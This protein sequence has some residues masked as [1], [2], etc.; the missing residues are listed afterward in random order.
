MTPAEGEACLSSAITEISPSR[1]MDFSNGIANGISLACRFNCDSGTR[2]I[3]NARSFWTCPAMSC[4]TSTMLKCAQPF[5]ELLQL[6][7]GL[8]R[9][10]ALFRDM[11]GFHQSQRLA[12]LS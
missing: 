4:N 9:L 10:N 1:R 3:S 7:E 5:F 2:C 6:G 8:F 12:N 11:I